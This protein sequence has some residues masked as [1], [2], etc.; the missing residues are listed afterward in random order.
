MLDFLKAL[1]QLSLGQREAL[2][3]HHV[4]GLSVDEISDQLGV[5][6]GTVKARLSRGRA[7]LARRLGL[8]LE[9]GRIVGG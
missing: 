6:A 8:D 9:G 4:V 7:A 5:P 2:V 3:L 1:Q